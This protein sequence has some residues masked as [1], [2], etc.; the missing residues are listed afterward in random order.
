MPCQVVVMLDQI[1]PDNA[2]EKAERLQA[3]VGYFDLDPNRVADLVLN[4]LEDNN[5]NT[6][7]AIT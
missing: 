6:G 5:A 3:I 1:T 4:Y 7:K 2:E